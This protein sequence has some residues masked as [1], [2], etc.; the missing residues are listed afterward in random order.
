MRDLLTTTL[1]VFAISTYPV[2]PSL[3]QTTAASGETQPTSET[4]AEEG[5]FVGLTEEEL[6]GCVFVK[7]VGRYGWEN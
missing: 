3:A 4:L 1:L 7:L 5:E 6:D 2:T